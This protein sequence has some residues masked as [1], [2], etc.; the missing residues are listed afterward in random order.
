MIKHVGAGVFDN[1]GLAASCFLAKSF[2]QQ[3][4]C[5]QAHSAEAGVQIPD[6]SAVGT[7][8]RDRSMGVGGLWG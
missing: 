3:D 1:A 8:E 7:D 5:A 2:M 4:R 6:K